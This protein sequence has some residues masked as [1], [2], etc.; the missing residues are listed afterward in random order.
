MA[1]DFTVSAATFEAT[2]QGLID[3]QEFAH[4]DATFMS[5]STPVYKAARPYIP[6][7]SQL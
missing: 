4:K 1:C 3:H 6:K 5:I 2:M 7:R